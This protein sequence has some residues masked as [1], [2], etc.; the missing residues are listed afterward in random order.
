MLRLLLLLLAPLTASAECSV[1]GDGLK[2]SAPDAIFAYPGQ[3]VVNCGDLQD[4]GVDGTVTV[5]ECNILATL[6]TDIC[7]CTQDG[8]AVAAAPVTPGPTV[9]GGT[10]APAP[11]P[12]GC[13]IC[14]VGKTVTLM[15]AIFAFP[16]EPIVPC[17]TLEAVGYSG[18]I[19]L[20]EC[21]F[22]PQYIQTICGC[23]P[24]GTPPVQAPSQ[25][26]L[27]Q[28]MI[29]PAQLFKQPESLTNNEGMAPGAIAGIIIGSIVG[30]ALLI[31]F[32]FRFCIRKSAQNKS[33]VTASSG[34][35]APPAAL[36]DAGSMGGTE[37]AGGDDTAAAEKELI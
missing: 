31:L 13:S 35:K 10:A 36:F 21:P 37:S 16:N 15:D 3:E 11:S 34:A 2:V 22:L 14:G 23:A 25:G 18:G 32:V 28:P 27:T 33:I 9:V 19:P 1:C 20:D 7:A 30:A 29:P 12:S 24:A 8:T 26:P 6:I 4:A 17:G 5:A